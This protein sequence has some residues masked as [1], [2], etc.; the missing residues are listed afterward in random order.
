[1]T[2]VFR[3]FLVTWCKI[4]YT[5]TKLRSGTSKTKAGAYFWKSHCATCSPVDVILYHVTRS[6][7][8]SIFQLYFVY[9]HRI[10]QEK[11]RGQRR[12]FPV[13]PLGYVMST[14]VIF[15]R[16]EV[17]VLAE[18]S[19]LRRPHVGQ[20]RSDVWKKSK[21]K[22]KK[23]V[24]VDEVSLGTWERGKTACGRLGKQTFAEKR[25]FR[26]IK[27]NFRGSTWHIPANALSFP[28]CPIIF[29][30]IN[31]DWFPFNYFI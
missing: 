21:K 6:C 13:Q 25:D 11:M 3:H 18:V 9:F 4:K 7:K 5:V 30:W 19:P 31:L 29:S 24:V 1:M 2:R 20:P 23:N 28:L 14:K 12:R 16:G 17:F 8:G 10:N 22:K 15:K 26:W 27:N